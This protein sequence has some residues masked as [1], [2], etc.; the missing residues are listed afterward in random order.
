MEHD[1]PSGLHLSS[2][3]VRL[4]LPGVQV[5]SLWLSSSS[6]SLPSAVSERERVH[7]YFVHDRRRRNYVFQFQ[8]EDAL[9]ALGAQSPQLGQLPQKSGQIIGTQ[10]FGAAARNVVFE[11]GDELVLHVLHSPRL[12]QTV[13]VCTRNKCVLD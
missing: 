4:L 13:P 10:R 11:A 8:V 3:S 12:L 1:D 7:E 9:E 6:N 2:G 5:I